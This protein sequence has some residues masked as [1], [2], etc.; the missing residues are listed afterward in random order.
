MVTILPPILIVV[1][2]VISDKFQEP[3]KAIIKV[4]IY[5]SKIAGIRLETEDPIIEENKIYEYASSVY[6]AID[7]EVKKKIGQVIKW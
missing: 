1:I 6:G 7:E 5:Q 4:F 3:N 2:F